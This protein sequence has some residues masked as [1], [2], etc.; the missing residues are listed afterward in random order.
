MTT[1]LYY[2]KSDNGNAGYY[3][4]TTAIALQ[5]HADIYGGKKYLMDLLKCKDD[6]D[7]DA[8]HNKMSERYYAKLKDI[9]NPLLTDR[10]VNN[11]LWL[12]TFSEHNTKDLPQW[13][14]YYENTVLPCYREED[15]NKLEVLHSKLKNYRA[16]THYMTTYDELADYINADELRPVWI[17][18]DDRDDSWDNDDYN[19]KQEAAQQA[20]EEREAIARDYLLQ[21]LLTDYTNNEL[22]A[23][24]KL[25][26]NRIKQTR[27]YRTQQRLRTIGLDNPAAELLA[28]NLLNDDPVNTGLLEHTDILNNTYYEGLHEL[29]LNRKP[30][31]Y[32][33]GHR[34]IVVKVAENN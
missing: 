7:R 18:Y 32:K 10:G 22:K 8:L 30:A 17:S 29:L 2:T 19:A 14:E 23:A 13:I 15:R 27:G 20:K 1:T 33:N 3:R 9:S 6:K 5:L 28:L 4:T 24:V 16:T 11:D 34:D 21:R 31:E 25:M 26:A 12:Y